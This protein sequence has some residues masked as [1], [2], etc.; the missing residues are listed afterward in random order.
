MT[1]EDQFEHYLAELKCLRDT[2]DELA[3]SYESNVADCQRLFE[4]I[5]SLIK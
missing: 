3:R 5:N 1:Y 2:L 4:K